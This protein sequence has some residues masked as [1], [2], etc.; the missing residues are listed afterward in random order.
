[1]PQTRSLFS[2][3]RSY[4]TPPQKKSS[5]RFLPGQWQT[6][7]SQP[8]KPVWM[9]RDYQRFADEAYIRNVI[10]YRSIHMVSSGAASVTL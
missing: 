6:F 3:V 10:A 9:N 7:M 5:A 1:M 4:F 8:G 2:R